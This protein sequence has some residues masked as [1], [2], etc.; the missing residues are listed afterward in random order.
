MT[1]LRVLLARIRGLFGMPASDRALND[2]IAVHLDMLADDYARRGMTAA[3][4]RAAARREF[5]GVDQV[6]E[7]YRDQRGWPWIED[8]VRD[9]RFAIRGFTSDPTFVLV[10]VVH[11]RHGYWREHRDLQPHGRRG[12][13]C[14]AVP[15]S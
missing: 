6:T 8:L 4:A 14:A 13:S 3:E 9:V 5:G 1:A 12:Y 15:R 7:R 10:A 2:E 11:T